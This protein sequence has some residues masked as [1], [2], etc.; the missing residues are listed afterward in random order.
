MVVAIGEFGRSP[1][2]GVSTSGELERS[3]G[4]DHCPIATALWLPGAG[5]PRARSWGIDRPHR[6]RRIKPVHAND[7]LATVYYALE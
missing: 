2:M 3:Y 5:S 4:R 6:R 1:R 7:L